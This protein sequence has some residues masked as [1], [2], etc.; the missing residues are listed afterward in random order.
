MADVTATAAK[1]AENL[2][3]FYPQGGSQLFVA[4]RMGIIVIFYFFQCD[5]LVGARQRRVLIILK[6]AIRHAAMQETP[7]WRLYPPNL[8]ICSPFYNND[9]DKYN[10]PFSQI[11]IHDPEQPF[12]DP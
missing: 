2:Q 1:K 5:L 9:S 4:E 7:T 11:Q 8:Y 12:Y 3:Q 6:T 10:R